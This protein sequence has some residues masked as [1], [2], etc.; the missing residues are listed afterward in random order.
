MKSR[1]GAML[2][3]IAAA[4]ASPAMAQTNVRIDEAAPIG[5]I[6]PEVHG[7]FVEH[8]GT[9]IYGG[10]WVGPDSKIPNTRGFRTDV[11]EALKALRV[12]VMRWP[13]GC[14]ADQYHWRDGVGARRT[15][16]D[17]LVWG[18]TPEPGTFGTHEFF[19]LAEMLGAK[20]YLNLN[21][22]TG[23]PQ[24]AAEWLEYITSGT[25]SALAQE[26]RA[27]G[28]D[29]PWTIDYLTL[30]N[31]TWDCGG[32]M[33]PAYYADLYAHWMTFAKTA[34]KQPFRVLSGS[35]DGNPEY[36]GA[37]LANPEV[38]P[39]TEGVSLHFYTL[40]T[41]NWD[42]KGADVGFP[43]AEWQSALRRGLRMGEII[44]TQLKAMDAAS[45][46]K[47][48]AIVPDEWGV[49]TDTPTGASALWQ[50]NTIREAV[51][52]AATLNAFQARADRVPMANIAQMV[53]VLQAMILTDGPRMVRTPTYHV[54]A[55]YQPFQGARAVPVKLASPM[56][57]APGGSYPALSASAAIDRDGAL[58]VALVNT[59]PSRSHDVAVDVGRRKLADARVLTGPA[60]DSHND[61][62]RPDRIVPVPFAFHGGGT[63]RATLPPRSVVVARFR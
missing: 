34:G 55:L 4:L 54:F 62:D 28:R 32:N 5:T 49:W 35:H 31:E 41:S 12:P 23:T 58:V 30:G 17:N 2:A 14:Y 19:D 22:G 8:L 59:D 13:G 9:Q 16:R 26:R 43:E 37:L 53:N 21:L 24:E 20:T 27:N 36:S 33:R 11:L 39:L 56:V 7:Q 25:N 6:A 42:K 38:A 18:H 3:A 60:I 50:Q 29:R 61:F 51:I 15:Q 44:D 48:L 52:A 10:I 47:K 57:A 46:G 40:P 63:P 45:P 1:F